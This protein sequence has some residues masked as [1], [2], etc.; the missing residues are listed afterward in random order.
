MK[1]ARCHH[2]LEPR[3]PHPGLVVIRNVASE[4]SAPLRKSIAVWVANPG[5]TV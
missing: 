1:I 2:E 5:G 4:L 3:E